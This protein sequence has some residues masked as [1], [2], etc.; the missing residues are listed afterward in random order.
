[1]LYLQNYVPTVFENYT[2]S[3]EIDKHRIELNMWDTSGKKLLLFLLHPRGRI[4]LPAADGRFSM[5]FRLQHLLFVAGP[6]SPLGPASAFLP[7]PSSVCDWLFPCFGFCQAPGGV[8][9]KGLRVWIIE[10]GCA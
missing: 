7:G 1:M 5:S 2:A 6:A 9:D 3:F 10:T 4:T 8:G